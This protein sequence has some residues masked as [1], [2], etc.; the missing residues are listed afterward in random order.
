MLGI[1]YRYEVL[2]DT[3]IKLAP[4]K[5]FI[6]ANIVAPFMAVGVLAIVGHLAE[7]KLEKE[8]A[9]D[10]KRRSSMHVHPSSR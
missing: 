5:G 8:S 10:L 6:I 4:T 7:R 3:K 1:K 2:D 9:E